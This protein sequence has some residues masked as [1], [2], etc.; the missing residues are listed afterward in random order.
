MEAVIERSND[1][2]FSGIGGNGAVKIFQYKMKT[3]KAWD[4]FAN[5]TGFTKNKKKTG[6]CEP[7]QPCAHNCKMFP[8]IA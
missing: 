5:K 2:E 4:S 8:C 1:N 3:C 6:L 7:G